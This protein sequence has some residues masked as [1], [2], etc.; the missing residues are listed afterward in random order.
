MRRPLILLGCLSLLATVAASRSA[1]SGARLKAERVTVHC[2][3]GQNEAFVT[4]KKVE[5]ALGDSVVWRMAGNV[6]SDSIIITLKDAEQVWP[7]AGDPPRG[8]ASAIASTARRVGTYGYNVT[9]YCRVPG[10]G[11][12]MEIIDPDIIIGE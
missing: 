10:G 5:I 4:P 7:F 12:R 6:A 2:S 8:G 9:L 3:N 11:T 1:P